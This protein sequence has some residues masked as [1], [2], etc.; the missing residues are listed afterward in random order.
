MA[1][2]SQLINQRFPHHV[3]VKIE[4]YFLKIGFYPVLVGIVT[5]DKGS[6]FDIEDYENNTCDCC[7]MGRQYSNE[8]GR[9][10]CNCNK[11]DN[12]YRNCSCYT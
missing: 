8:F 3:A 1:T 7:V 2:T 5:K 6:T 9:C 4:R 10:N 11:C 12:Y